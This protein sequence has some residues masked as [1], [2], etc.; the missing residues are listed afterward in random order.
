[1]ELIHYAIP[2]FILLMI[3]EAIFSAVQDAQLYEIKDTFA[4]LAMGLGNVIV[5]L[6]TKVPIYG[7]YALAY[8][9]RL[10]DIEPVW[11]A[12]V[13]LL[14]LDDITYY[15]YHRYS[16]EIRFMWASHVNHHSS[17]KYNLS[18]A[19]RQTWTGALSLGFLFWV[20]L[21]LLGFHPMMVMTMQSISL[22]YQFWIHTET[23][24]KLGPLEWFMNTPSH[25]RVHH[26]SDFKY[27][28]R[29]HGGIFIIWDRLFGTFQPEEEPVTFGL[30]HNINTYNPIRIAFH[31][32]QDMIRD[33]RRAPT[34]RAKLGY[35]FCPPGWSHDG[36]SKSVRRLRAELRRGMM[37]EPAPE[38]VTSSTRQAAPSQSG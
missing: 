29:N 24:G 26:G 5:K 27:L 17:Q 36:S 21:P 3:V 33:V 12:W 28:D 18:T 34:L 9:F 37:G 30:T 10:F 31:E 7:T 6:F 11:W 8:Q 14:F 4:S 13:L 38:T 1:M 22:L 25:H 23:I 2:A 20:W 15:F 32:W 35:I 19:L 16:H